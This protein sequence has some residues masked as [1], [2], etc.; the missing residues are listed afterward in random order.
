MY[1][2]DA[3]MPTPS[4]WLTPAEGASTRHMHLLRQAGRSVTLVHIVAAAALG[5]P[6]MAAENLPAPAGQPLAVARAAAQEF[7]HGC[8]AVR[9]ARLRDGKIRARCAGGS[10]VLIY[11]VRGFTPVIVMDCQQALDFRLTCRN[12]RRAA[13][14]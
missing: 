11:R 13:A 12:P 5:C 8:N 10:D 7:G 3:P 9:A 4:L 6:A 1:W 14:R 2:C